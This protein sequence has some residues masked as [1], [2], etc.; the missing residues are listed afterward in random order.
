MTG[1]LR[2]TRP[3]KVRHRGGF[4]MLD[5]KNYAAERGYRGFG[6]R[7][8]SLK[9]IQYL[10]APIVPLKLHGYHHYVVF[11]GLTPKGEVHIADPAFGNRWLSRK[12][13]DKAWIDG[14]AFV[15]LRG[16]K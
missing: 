8:L 1:L 4:S 14:I 5:M 6:F 12:A 13:F 9:D 11:E 7:G 10:D 15:M 2:Q 16:T 3:L